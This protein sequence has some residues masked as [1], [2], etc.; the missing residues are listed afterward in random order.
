MGFLPIGLDEHYRVYISEDPIGLKG[1]INKYAYTKNNPA[2]QKDPKGLSMVPGG[3]DLP[4]M[5]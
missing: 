3:P 2:S 5:P 4:G 1:G